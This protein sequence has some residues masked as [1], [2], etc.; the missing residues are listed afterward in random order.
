MR[1]DLYMK[2]RLHDQVQ[3]E[4]VMMT[5]TTITKSRRI[6]LT[7]TDENDVDHEFG[8]FDL[9]EYRDWPVL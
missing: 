4:G 2:L 1:Y 5:V 6:R 7:W 9:S 3:Y 8:P